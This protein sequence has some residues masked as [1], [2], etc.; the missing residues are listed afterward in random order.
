MTA[1]DTDKDSTRQEEPE[2]AQMEQEINKYSTNSVHGRE[3]C[4][5][6]LHQSMNILYKGRSVKKQGLS[7]YPWLMYMPRDSAGVNVHIH[8]HT[9]TAHHRL[10]V[11]CAK[12]IE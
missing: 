2:E 5:E 9:V 12:Q 4:F 10:L 7:S 6:N 8:T 11:L 3:E 1:T